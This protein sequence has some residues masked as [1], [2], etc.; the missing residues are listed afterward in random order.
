M[1]QPDHHDDGGD[2]PNAAPQPWHPGDWVGLGIVMALFSSAG[3]IYSTAAVV[4]L[5]LTPRCD[6]S[7]RCP[8]DS[9]IL[10]LPTW[11]A[12]IAVLVGLGVVVRDHWRGQPRLRR[13]VVW[14]AAT[15]V[16]LGVISLGAL[17]D[18]GPK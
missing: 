5:Q 12:V 1:K 10:T 11:S 2:Q 16:V 9:P 18:L 13:A 7:S 4:V 14:T 15:F 8:L 17:A 6:P 3:L